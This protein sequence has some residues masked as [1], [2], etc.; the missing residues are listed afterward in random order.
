M[1]TTVSTARCACQL[2]QEER[3]VGS[4]PK[5][6]IP[7]LH[8]LFS[9]MDLLGSYRGTPVWGFAAMTAYPRHGDKPRVEA[10]GPFQISAGAEFYDGATRARN[11]D[12]IQG[13]I[14]VIQTSSA[15]MVTVDSFYVKELVEDHFCGKGKQGSLDTTN[16]KAVTT[17]RSMGTG[18][19]GWRGEH[20]R[21]PLGGMRDTACTTTSMVAAAP[22][23]WR[24]RLLRRS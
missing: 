24:R 16:E 5:A 22:V 17:L 1:I 20:R 11:T 3:A 10:C 13:L 15:L 14:E 23:E 18:P 2:A 19:H 9:Q 6:T 12:E 21:R 8:S 4:R 7:P